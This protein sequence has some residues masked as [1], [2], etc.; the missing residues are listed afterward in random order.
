[1]TEASERAR[2]LIGALFGES[3]RVRQMPAN[4]I[5]DE[6]EAPVRSVRKGR[7]R[8]PTVDS[9][10][11]VSV[12]QALLILK[13]ALREELAL[14]LEAEISHLD[15]ELRSRVLAALRGQR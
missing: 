7:R 9:P 14:E 5:E 6:L 4:W 15:P 13:Q 2:D 12:D 3:V 8:K 1:M 11:L 10:P